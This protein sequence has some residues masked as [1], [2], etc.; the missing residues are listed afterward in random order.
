MLKFTKRQKSVILDFFSI[1]GVTELILLFYKFGLSYP[2]DWRHFLALPLYFI[3][4]YFILQYAF[5]L[6]KILW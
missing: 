6:N 4:V 5:K 1:A 2:A 3:V